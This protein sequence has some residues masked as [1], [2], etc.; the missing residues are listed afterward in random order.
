MRESLN[1][2]QDLILKFHNCTLDYF[3]LQKE[4]F[5]GPLIF[6]CINLNKMKFIRFIFL[7]HPYLLKYSKES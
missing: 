1:G 2:L 3:D 6:N 4:M 5:D 7:Q